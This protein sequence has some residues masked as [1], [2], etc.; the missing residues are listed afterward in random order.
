MEQFTQTILRMKTKLKRAKAADPHLKVFGAERHR[1]NVNPPIPPAAVTAFEAEYKIQVPDGYK[2]FV[3]LFGNGGSSYQGSAAGPFYGIFPFGQGLNL[4][5]NARE[6]LTRA[7]CIEPAMSDAYWQEIIHIIEEKEENDAITDAEYEAETVKIFGG[8]LPIGSQGCSYSH[9]L[10]LNGPHA[11]KVVNVSEELDKPRFTF[12]P[13][14]LG[15]YERWLDEVIAG[16]LLQDGPQWFGYSMGGTEEALFERFVCEADESTKLDCLSGMLKKKALHIPLIDKIE[17]EYPRYQGGI[18]Q[19]LL[20]ILTKFDYTRAKPYLLEAGDT[21]LL[22]VCKDIYWYAKDKCK[23][24]TAFIKHALPQVHDDDTFSFCTYILKE[25]GAEDAQSI[26]PFTRHPDSKIRR[27][28]FY[29][30]GDLSDKARYLDVFI[31]GLQDSDNRVLQTT[32]QALVGVK[33]TRLL[34]LYKQVALRFP[35]EQDYILCNLNHRLKDFDL[36][37]TSI[38]HCGTV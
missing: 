21:D 18:K 27:T 14:F 30:L 25:A 37:N 20:R 2:A 31:Q 15:W 8:L 24:W 5:A 10:V 22:T 28:A 13:D 34:P 17:M 16:D 35:L 12:E 4:L 7:C 3:T 26:I 19:M 11:G 38:I 1:Y 29:R 9:C 6:A 36:D 23:E 32:L 33:D